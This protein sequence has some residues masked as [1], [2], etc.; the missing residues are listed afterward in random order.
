MS[1]PLEGHTVV[2]TRPA[3][4]A[5]RFL[6]LAHEA[7]ADCIALPT[8]AIEPL[9]IAPKVAA[10]VRETRWDWA[11]YTSANAIECV[12]AALGRLPAAARTAA[13]GRATA[14]ALERH[15]LSVDLRPDSAT[16]EGLL[17]T[18]QFCAVAGE[19]ILLVKGEGGRDLLRETL[20]ARGARVTV[21]A[22]YRRLPAEP[23]ATVVERLREALDPGGA[24]RLAVVVTSA[25][26]LEAL[27]RILPSDVAQALA[28]AP[29][30]A[31]GERV[32][33]AARR[34]GWRG[35]VVIAATAEDEAMLT[36]LRDYAA[37][38]PHGPAC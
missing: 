26:V 21:L 34:L 29:L 8:L 4:Q 25:E 3:A 5:G 10:Q 14:R 17:A 20:A 36:A 30:V 12:R 27:L 33:A 6:G 24:A 11:V 31:P 9:A 1:R 18:P 2:V 35:A 7:G 16:S 22:V 32:A 28:A 23:D 15:A 37:A 13:V 19:S 38:R